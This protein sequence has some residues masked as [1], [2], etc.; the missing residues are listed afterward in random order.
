MGQDSQGQLFDQLRA[1][2]ITTTP[3]VYNERTCI[4]LNFSSYMKD[5]VSL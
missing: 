2:T 1:T 5:V 4:F 3:I